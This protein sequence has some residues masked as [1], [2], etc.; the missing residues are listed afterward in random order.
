MPWAQQVALSQQLGTE[1]FVD[2]DTA[3]EQAVQDKQA[4]AVAELRGVLRD[5]ASG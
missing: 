3:D 1:P 4:E 5:P 2:P